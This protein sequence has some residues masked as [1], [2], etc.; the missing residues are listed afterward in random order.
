MD[1][2]TFADREAARI[3]HHEARRDLRDARRGKRRD[4]QDPAPPQADADEAAQDFDTLCNERT[5]DAAARLAAL[6]AE[7]LGRG[8]GEPSAPAT[9]KKKARRA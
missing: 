8:E 3:R 6:D 5:Q 4:G 1:I 7:F 2:I 9:T